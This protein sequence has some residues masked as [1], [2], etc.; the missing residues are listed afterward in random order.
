MLRKYGV[1]ITTIAEWDVEQIRAFIAAGAPSAARRWETEVRRQIASLKRFPLRAP[2]IP[3]A[4][5]LGVSYRHGPKTTA[6]SSSA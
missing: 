2:L 5:D 6:S 3:E 1:D 4:T